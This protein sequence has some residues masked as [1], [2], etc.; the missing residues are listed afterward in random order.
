MPCLPHTCPLS[1]L[2]RRHARIRDFL[3]LSPRSLRQGA[4]PA[5]STAKGITSGIMN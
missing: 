2:H 5:I 4:N 1:A 3:P